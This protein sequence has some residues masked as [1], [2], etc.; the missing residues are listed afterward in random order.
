MNGHFHSSVDMENKIYNEELIKLGKRIRAL[1]KA[2]NKTQLDL[3][4]DCKINHG[5]ISRI[6][7]GQKNLEFFTIVRLALALK[8]KVT[9]LFKEDVE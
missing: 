5:D 3:E 8:V 4:F 2:M 9:D 1:R 6:E 7:N